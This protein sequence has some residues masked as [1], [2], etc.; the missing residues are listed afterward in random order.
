MDHS[1]LRRSSACVCILLSMGL[2]GCAGGAPPSGTSPTGVGPSSQP[3][4]LYTR[5][6]YGDLLV[7]QIDLSTG[8]PTAIQTV[9]PPS[10]QNTVGG[11]PPVPDPRSRFMYTYE[12][13]IDGTVTHY[14]IAA[15]AIA[16]DGTLSLINGSPFAIPNPSPV[17][18]PDFGPLVIN[19]AGTALYAISADAWGG[20][21]GFHI[22][23]NSGTLTSMA[24]TFSTGAFTGSAAIGPKGEFLYLAQTLTDTPSNAPGIG[25]FEI[26]A[27]TG[28]LTPLANSPVLLPATALDQP[29]EIIFDP[30]G[31][32]LYVNLPDAELPNDIGG[33]LRDSTSGEL[34]PMP[35]SPFVSE[36]ATNPTATS[37]AMHP[38]GKFLYVENYNGGPVSALAI[39]PNSGVLSPVA[40]SPF[41]PQVSNRNKTNPPTIVEGN[42]IA[43]DPSG[44]YLYLSGNDAEIVVYSINQTTGALEAVSGSPFPIS[45]APAHLTIVQSPG[46]H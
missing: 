44:K 25:E 23:P 3:E 8:T 21:A 43:V 31:H 4:F 18:P 11:G 40:G 41:P 36:S 19:P 7:F 1:F 32:F 26:D 39:D 27:S 46:T 10:G 24:S 37:M 12:P 33:F 34:T 22:D 17:A 16:A 30:S 6:E 35:G 28:N 2:N 38:S 29:G 20:V 42:A 13:H 15:Y 45:G 9:N 14:S 5:D